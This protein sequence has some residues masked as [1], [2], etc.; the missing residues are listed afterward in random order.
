LISVIFDVGRKNEF[1]NKRLS[2]IAKAP[3]KLFFT[4]ALKPL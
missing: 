3:L 2:V 4:G 1:W